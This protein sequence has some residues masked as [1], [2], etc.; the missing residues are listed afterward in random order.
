MVQQNIVWHPA[1]ITKTD[2]HKVNKH[3]SCALW[4]TG[5]SGSGKSTLANEL[6]RQLYSLKIKSYV[7][8]GDN[9]R[10]GLNN[11]L[12]FSQKDR[13][14]NVRRVGEVAK[15]FVDS[16][17]IVMTAFISPYRKERNQVRNIFEQ[18]E[19]IE[20][21]IKCPL[22]VCELRD[23]KGIYQKAR[24]G[25]IRN[26]TGID[27]PYESPLNPDLTIDTEQYSVKEAARTIIAHL[28]NKG[29]IDLSY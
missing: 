25:K 2:R 13:L 23:P 5:L 26:F 1:T 11:D 28:Q 15:L 24:N 8:D 16:G 18:E 4:F 21:F 10:K 12:G 29:I 14:E 9:V 17:L 6:D 22:E 27:S 20:V 3:K 19:F 7:L